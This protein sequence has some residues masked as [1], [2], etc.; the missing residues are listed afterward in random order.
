M[1]YILINFNLLNELYCE[2][3][4]HFDNL[5]INFLMLIKIKII[6]YLK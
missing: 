4:I 3:I 1:Y 2:I 5:I 6:K